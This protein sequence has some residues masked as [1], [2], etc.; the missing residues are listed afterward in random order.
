M[1]INQAPNSMKVTSILNEIAGSLKVTT[2]I[3]NEI[4]GSLVRSFSTTGTGEI[5]LGKLCLRPLLLD[6]GGANRT[7]S[8]DSYCHPLGDFEESNNME[9]VE[10]RTRAAD[11]ISSG[12]DDS[13]ANENNSVS[14]ERYA[15]LRNHQ[16]RFEDAI[17]PTAERV[18]EVDK[19][20]VVFG[21]GRG[22]QKHPGNIRMREIVEKY[23]TRYHSLNRKGKR[24]LAIAV[25]EE[26]S[27]GGIR[28]LKKLNNEEIWVIVD[29]PIAMQ[30]V[31]HTLRCRKSVLKQIA[32]ED[33]EVSP[34][35]SQ[36]KPVARNEIDTT[37]TIANGFPEG[38]SQGV[39]GASRITMS[40]PASSIVNL[41]ILELE[42]Q[43][44]AA[45]E[46]YRKLAG[47]PPVLPPGM[48]YYEMVRREQLIRETALLQ[49]MGDPILRNSSTSRSLSTASLA[50]FSTPLE[51][52][53]PSVQ[54]SKTDETS[55]A[56]PGCSNICRSKK[57]TTTT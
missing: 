10:G 50:P 18:Y 20:D 24:K 1:T 13:T 26:I 23:K 45:L 55:D 22:H 3:L 5:S 52:S 40:S 34:A 35:A 8:L 11:S 12:D 36:D 42:A 49:K 32:K 6:A 38:S 33:G 53:R 44:M 46:R 43:R 47:L 54:N 25:H 39:A 19:M 4:A 21:R 56:T 7:H 30:K 57:P 48:N 28:F 37:A 31:A 16:I 15:S 27:E 41:S 29:F 14:D 51:A 9:S 2:S 17:D